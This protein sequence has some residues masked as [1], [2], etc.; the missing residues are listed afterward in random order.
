MCEVPTP[1]IHRIDFMATALQ[2]KVMGIDDIVGFG[3][4]DP[5]KP[6]R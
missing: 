1:A 5:P 6:Q 4:M 2:L 3:F